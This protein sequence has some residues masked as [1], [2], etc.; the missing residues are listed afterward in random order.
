MDLS[1]S[2]VAFPYWALTVLPLIWFAAVAA[3]EWTSWRCWRQLPHRKSFYYWIKQLPIQLPQ[4]TVFHF[5]LYSRARLSCSLSPCG[6][7]W[8]YVQVRWYPLKWKLKCPVSR[9]L[10]I[11]ND[12]QNKF[13]SF[14]ARFIVVFVSLFVDEEKNVEKL[15]TQFR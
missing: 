15:S 10:K 4:V 12:C 6:R 9:T 1:R 3:I 7:V 14:R 11:V 2:T 8:V 13:P 5:V